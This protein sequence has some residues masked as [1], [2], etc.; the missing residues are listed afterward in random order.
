MAHSYWPPLSVRGWPSALGMRDADWGSASEDYDDVASAE[1][2]RRLHELRGLIV[3]QVAEIENLLIH[4]ADQILSR[5]PVVA[6]RPVTQRQYGAGRILAVVEN[7]LRALGLS[8]EFED[9]I[10]DI[11]QTIR[12]RNDIVHAVIRIGFSDVGE[13]GPRVSVISILQDN[14]QAIQPEADVTRENHGCEGAAECPHDIE[15]LLDFSWDISEPRLEQQLNNAY[16]ALEK[17]IDI[18][19]RVNQVL[20]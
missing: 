19:V 12:D 11:R 18:W 7:Q 15:D 4:I 13:H 17:C 9:S 14:N 8:G 1:E 10:K 6:S 16:S 20:L 2:S 5:T 3:G